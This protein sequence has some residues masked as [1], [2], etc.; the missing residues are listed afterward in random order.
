[1]SSSLK[2][3]I[4]T[5]LLSVVGGSCACADV[6][7]AQKGVTWTK[8]VQTHQAI[9]GISFREAWDDLA[10]RHGRPK[11]SEYFARNAPRTVRHAADTVRIG[12]SFRVGIEQAEEEVRTVSLAGNTA[13]NVVLCVPQDVCTGSETQASQCAVAD[14]KRPTPTEG[15]SEAEVP[16]LE[17]PSEYEQTQNQI[18]LLQAQNLALATLIESVGDANLK[19]QER[20][21]EQQNRYSKYG[22]VQGTEDLSQLRNDS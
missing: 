9:V 15:Y 13:V 17:E 8:V 22:G 10:V 14:S 18:A 7:V 4:L 12:E 6:L 1:M 5:I 20:F 3:I 11:Y 2:M 21:R 19:W 16:L